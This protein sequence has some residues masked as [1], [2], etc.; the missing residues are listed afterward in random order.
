MKKLNSSMCIF[1][2]CYFQYAGASVSKNCCF[3]SLMKILMYRQFKQVTLKCKDY[4]WQSWGCN[5]TSIPQSTWPITGEPVVRKKNSLI[6]RNVEE[7]DVNDSSLLQSI[8]TKYSDLE[9]IFQIRAS[10]CN[11][12]NRLWGNFISCDNLL[13]VKVLGRPRWVSE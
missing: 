7:K 11:T 13:I 3:V 8:N 10:L 5:Q 2:I 6:L 1:M 4:N 12:S 9:L